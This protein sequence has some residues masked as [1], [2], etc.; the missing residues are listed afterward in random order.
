M[1][2]GALFHESKQENFTV[3]LHEKRRPGAGDPLFSQTLATLEVL[4][5]K[6]AVQYHSGNRLQGTWTR[7]VVD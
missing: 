6:G 1:S 3:A 4:D 7:L 2:V 5:G